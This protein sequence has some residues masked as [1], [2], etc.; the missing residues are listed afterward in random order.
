MATIV[1]RPSGKWQATVRHDGKSCSKSFTKR[2]DATKWARETEILAELGSGLHMISPPSQ[3]VT[4]AQVLERFRDDVV[5]THRS[6]VNETTS[7]NAMLRDHRQLAHTRLDELTSTDVAKWRDKRLQQVKPSTVVR[8]MTLVQ[9]AIQHIL[10]TEGKPGSVNVLKQVKRP[11]VDDRRERRL[12]PGEWQRLLDVIDNQRTPMM[13]PLLTLALET[14]M[15]RGELLAM[16]WQHVD[17]DRCTVLLPRTKNGHARTVPL[18]PTAVQVLAELPRTGLHV[19]PISAN[20]VRLAFHRFRTRA[21]I[22]DLRLHDLRHECVS[23]L[24]ERGLSIAEVQMVSGHRDVSMLLRYTH[25]QTADI[26]MKL[27]HVS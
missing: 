3:T 4:L 21:G 25:L 14:G 20:A 22:E 16:Q 1:K 11:R 7:I 26:V 18:S 15:R 6:G 24:V 12:Q 2:S 27:R 13:R 10:D 8:E 23:R 5:P 17:I 9:S 19:L